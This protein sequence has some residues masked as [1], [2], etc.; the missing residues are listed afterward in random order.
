M[1]KYLIFI[2]IKEQPELTRLIKVLSEHMEQ[3]SKDLAICLD[4]EFWKSYGYSRTWNEMPSNEEKFL[5][6]RLSDTKICLQCDKCLKWR[7]HPFTEDFLNVE[8]YPPDNWSCELE[9]YP[10]M[11]FNQSKPKQ[12]EEMSSAAKPSTS[13]SSS[14]ARSAYNSFQKKTNN[15]KLQKK[16]KKE[17][18]SV[19]KSFE[20]H[21]RLKE[22]LSL[23]AS[24]V[25][26]QKR[27]SQDNDE[28][29]DFEN[30]KDVEDNNNTNRAK[31]RHRSHKNADN[32][33]RNIQ[34]AKKRSA[35]K[36]GKV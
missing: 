18:D 6:K 33:Y 15:D 23:S 1:N 17:A 21:K 26:K 7:M 24:S 4:H 31:V 36:K 22:S 32:N 10:K 11:E 14:L 27:K 25:P 34:V 35:A 3:Y 8:N 19:R 13:A 16:I 2:V 9:P 28:D 29:E 20:D 30:V 5:K 12:I